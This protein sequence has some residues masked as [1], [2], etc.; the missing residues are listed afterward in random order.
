MSLN[1]PE[2]VTTGDEAGERA[3]RLAMIRN[4]AAIQVPLRGNDDLAAALAQVK[5][6][7][8][9][10]EAQAERLFTDYGL[11][12]CPGVFR[13]EHLRCCLAA[14]TALASTNPIGTIENPID[15]TGAKP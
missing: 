4:A 15:G 10:L 12:F 11:C 9:A 8:E 14:K 3:E 5:T 2:N 1:K 6:L 7:R 13:G